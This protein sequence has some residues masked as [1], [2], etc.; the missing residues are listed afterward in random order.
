MASQS[1]SVLITGEDFVNRIV[2]RLTAS[3]LRWEF[4]Q[5]AYSRA[6]IRCWAEL[7]VRGERVLV[8]WGPDWQGTDV[9]GGL[10]ESIVSL[11]HG[12][13]L[14]AA[15]TELRETPVAAAVEGA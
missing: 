5:L 4:R 10:A 11:L 2:E 8:A 13:E 7:D 1:A 14:D 9:I 12:K 3:K 6:A 15:V